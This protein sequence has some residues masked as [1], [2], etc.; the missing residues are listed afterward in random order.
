MTSI[1]GKE[2]SP[3]NGMQQSISAEALAH[4]HTLTWG[5]EQRGVTY[6]STYLFLVPSV[7]F[8]CSRK[9]SRNFDKPQTEGGGG[10]PLSAERITLL[11]KVIP[12]SKRSTL[13]CVGRPFLRI[14]ATLNPGTFS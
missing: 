11:G 10:G 3:F 9:G 6:S 12:L 13:V 2:N 8:F 7:C 4:T 1:K 5:N 14:S